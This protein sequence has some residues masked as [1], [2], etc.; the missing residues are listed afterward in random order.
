M[1]INPSKSTA[2]LFGKRREKKIISTD[3]IKVNVD[4]VNIQ[5]SDCI[6][7]L[8]IQLD[9]KLRFREHI[10][11]LIRLSYSRLKVLYG[12]R[13]SLTV[14]V[15]KLL[16]NSLVLSYLNYCDSVYGPCID[17]VDTYRLQKVQNA[18]MRFIFGIRKYEHVSHCLPLL[19][20]L[21][22]LNG[23]QLHSLCLYHKLMK[24]QQPAYLYNKITFRTDVH[25]LNLRFRHL[26][27][28]PQHRYEIFKRSFTYQ[29]VSCYNSVPE[30]FKQYSV[31]TF[32]RLM[33][34]H[35][36]DRQAAHLD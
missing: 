18:C 10:T 2:I 11:N 24:F 14:S 8:G 21:N 32:K 34:A 23:R 4:G 36:L 20:W 16:C 33:R 3:S 31:T 13:A 28:P 9:N 30:H 19:N 27:T 1:Q 17:S 29:I 15:R 7:S 6:K 12:S 25:N 5:L 26:L 35:L 22:M